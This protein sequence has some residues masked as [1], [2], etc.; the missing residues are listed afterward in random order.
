V[1]LEAGGV[2]TTDEGEAVFPVSA[3]QAGGAPIALLAGQPASHAAAVRDVRAARRGAL[4]LS[5]P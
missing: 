1:V 4:T 5:T 3:A 2:L